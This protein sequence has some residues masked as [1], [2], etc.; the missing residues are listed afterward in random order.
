M[1]GDVNPIDAIFMFQ[2]FSFVFFFQV[3]L[4]SACFAYSVATAL[5]QYR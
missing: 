1:A 2:T 5:L 3:N 4:S